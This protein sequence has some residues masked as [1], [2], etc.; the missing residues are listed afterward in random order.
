VRTEPLI[1]PLPAFA[2]SPNKGDEFG[3][4]PVVLFFDEQGKVE[5]IL[6]PS[7]IY[8]TGTGLKG[9]FRWLGYLPNEAKY[10]LI[11]IQSLD[12]D[13]DFLADFEAPRLGEGG[14]WAA[15]VGV[16]FERDPTEV[17][18]G[19]GPDS[20]S[21]DKAGF[22]R[23]DL[24]GFLSLGLN[25]LERFRISYNER[26]RHALLEGGG[27]VL[28]NFIGDGFPDAP[29]VKTWTTISARGLNLTY[30]TRD[31][32]TTPTQGVFGLVGFELSQTAWGSETS[33][34][35]TFGEV[36]AYFP[37][38]ST[39]W[40]SAVRLAGSFVDNDNLPH[41]EQS[42]LGGSDFRGFPSDRFV[43]RGVFKVNLEERVRVLR[44]ELLRVPF[45]VET[46]PFVEVGQVFHSAGD[47]QF[48]QIRVSY[49]VGFRAVVRPNVVGK[50][51]VGAADEGMNIRV[52]IDY[53]F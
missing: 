37:W 48:R 25:F 13:S 51:D 12:V 4:L 44:V 32:G 33:F 24:K 17:F 43:D 35:R 47:I 7:A 11:A 15:S 34:T 14:M 52:G 49:G 18:F 36:K 22:T 2:T 28:E 30:D 8:N 21:E 27:R 16:R 23:R 41:Y 1:L 46:A 39:Q 3:L 45:D 20:R 9:A 10:R 40:I 5:S 53:P 19:F 38:P 50:I 26:L 29:G 31:S 6:A 42:I